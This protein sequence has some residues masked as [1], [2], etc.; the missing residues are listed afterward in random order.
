MAQDSDHRSLSGL[1]DI[2]VSLRP[3]RAEFRR[4][5]ED[6]AALTQRFTA[7]HQEIREL[8]E[9]VVASA[10][11]QGVSGHIGAPVD[12]AGGGNTNPLVDVRL[13]TSV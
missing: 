1:D 9:R 5:K 7:T 3:I 4:L 10:P 2:A 12:R 6:L 11:G 8:R 13:N